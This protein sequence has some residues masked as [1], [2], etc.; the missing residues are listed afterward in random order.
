ME[1]TLI[2]L[3]TNIKDEDYY[4]L[5]YCSAIIIYTE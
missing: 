3:E 1:E 5:D 4:S 2:D